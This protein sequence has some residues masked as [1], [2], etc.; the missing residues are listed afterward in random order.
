[1]TF[2]FTSKNGKVKDFDHITHYQRERGP[3]TLLT[4]SLLPKTNHLNCK[5][6]NAQK[7]SSSGFTICKIIRNYL[8][9]TKPQ[10]YIKII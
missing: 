3:L 8:Y 5:I 10:V 7:L 2:F 1:M 6:L 9:K 4:P